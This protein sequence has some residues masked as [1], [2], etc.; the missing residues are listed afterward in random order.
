MNADGTYA[1]YYDDGDS[2]EAVDSKHVKLNDKPVPLSKT[3]PKAEVPQV[4]QT[5]QQKSQNPHS[6]KLNRSRKSLQ[7]PHHRKL[8][9]CRTLQQ[10]H[11]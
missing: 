10:R 6:R 11:S 3:K 5:L 8:N 2:E 7:D 9:W 4:P 1:I